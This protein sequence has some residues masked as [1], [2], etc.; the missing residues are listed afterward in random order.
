VIEVPEAILSEI[1]P[2]IR[3][4]G[5]LQ[6]ILA[7]VR[8]G[9]ERGGVDQ[10]VS[11][12]EIDRDPG[13]QRAFQLEGTLRNPA[14]SIERSLELAVGR[15]VM[16]KLRVIDGEKERMWYFLNTLQNAARVRAMVNGLESPPKTLWAA[17]SAPRV[18]SERPTVFR[19]Y[20]QN[21]GPLT[22][23]VA[24]RLLDALEV[25]PASWIEDAVAEAVGYN[26]RSWRYISR[27]LENWQV[28]RWQSTDDRE[29][30]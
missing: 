17:G 23:L 29:R 12:E 7:V 6:L 19:L 21:I 25:Y 20:E 3:D 11:R 4:V 8:M 9:T 18:E 15:G 26:K 5:E 30:R 10:P 22:P 24:Q 27:I 14:E 13:V 1:A 16:I 2:Q 28:E